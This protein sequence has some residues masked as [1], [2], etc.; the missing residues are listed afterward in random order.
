MR[1]FSTPIGRMHMKSAAAETITAPTVT[2]PKLTLRMSGSSPASSRAQQNFAGLIQAYNALT[3]AQKR[4]WQIAANTLNAQQN[5]TGR[6]KLTAPN[7][8]CSIGS[9][10]L[11]LN[12]FPPT[13]AP[14]NL[15]PPPLLVNTSL[16]AAAPVPNEDGT[17]NGAF[18]LLVYAPNYNFPV[19]V[20]AA[21]PSP[22]AKPTIPDSAFVPIA[23]M[24]SISPV[25]TEI[26]YEYSSR[27]GI[28]EVGAEVALR[29]VA[30]SRV[31]VRRNPL[32]I[33]GIV[34]AV[35][36]DTSSSS[37]APQD[38]QLHVV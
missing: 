6:H 18:S 14:A 34:T 17:T 33:S 15:A 38:T 21:A 23:L 5:R 36:P 26:S 35:P 27:F 16:A 29:L 25:G 28:P 37:P 22:G 3:M 13:D 9:G 12:Q 20:L 7:A 31:G 4:G 11:A 19:H 2:A 1:G 24:D 30:I 8:Y 32:T 10:C